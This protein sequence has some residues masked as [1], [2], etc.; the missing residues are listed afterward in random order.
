MIIRQP[1]YTKEEYARRSGEIY[2]QQIRPFLT[3]GNKGKIVATDI[4]TGA[5]VIGE[6]ILSASQ[7]LID[8][9]A[10][11]QI[12]VVRVGHRAVR[13]IRSFRTM[14]YGA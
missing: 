13:Q 14:V 1:R 8:R 6:D 5:H 3:E 2:Q 11:A 9:N 10:D 7:S 12:W 4:E